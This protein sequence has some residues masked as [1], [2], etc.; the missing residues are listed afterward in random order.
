M[1]SPRYCYDFDSQMVRGCF[2]DTDPDAHGR[3]IIRLESD[4]SSLRRPNTALNVEISD[5]GGATC[6]DT[7]MLAPY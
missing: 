7:I 6:S 3:Q 4:S 5:N 2:D 1:D